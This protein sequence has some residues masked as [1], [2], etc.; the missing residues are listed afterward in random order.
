MIRTT[1]HEELADA[2]ETSVKETESLENAQDTKQ[3]LEKSLEFVIEVDEKDKSPP[4]DIMQTSLGRH[5][6]EYKNSVKANTLLD[7][8][9]SVDQIHQIKR[10][11][12]DNKIK[13]FKYNYALEDIVQNFSSFQGYI[14]LS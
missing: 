11:L 10:Y 13:C 6:T 8:V 4:L 5:I 9:D 3:L 12:M 14:K 1:T 2:E 7:D